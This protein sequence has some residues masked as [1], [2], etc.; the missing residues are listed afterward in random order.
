MWMLLRRVGGFRPPTCFCAGRFTRHPNCGPCAASV[1]M[2]SRRAAMYAQGVA[3]GGALDR[4][5][6]P[7]A[8]NC[9]H[10]HLAVTL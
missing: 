7:G 8:A 5:V 1:V 6:Q 9:L 3:V 10:V 2:C 4:G